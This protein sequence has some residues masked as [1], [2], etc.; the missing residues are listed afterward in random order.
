MGQYIFA[1]VDKHIEEIRPQN[2]VQVVTDNATNKMAAT[3]IVKENR[4]SILWTSCATHQLTLCSKELPNNKSSRSNQES[5]YM[6]IFIYGHARTLSLVRKHTKSR[7][8]TW[9]G[10]T[11][12]AN[13]YKV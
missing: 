13:L 10:V 11:R 5:K 6:T 7:K 12:F 9:L 1:Y 3:N 2:T 8:I 4:P